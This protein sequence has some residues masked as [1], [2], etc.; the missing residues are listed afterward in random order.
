VC[1]R[2]GGSCQAWHGWSGGKGALEVR[3]GEG[4]RPFPPA[5]MAL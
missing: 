3:A 4:N 5:V 1:P 2:G